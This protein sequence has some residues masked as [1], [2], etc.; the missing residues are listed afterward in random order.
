MRR[1]RH[2]LK[3]LA[4]WC[5]AHTEIAVAD[6]QELRRLPVFGVLAALGAT[7]LRRSPQTSVTA[8]LEPSQL[9]LSAYVRLSMQRFIF[10]METL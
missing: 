9:T 1:P 5:V 8:V 4:C 10:G 6:Y 3:A 2:H 7:V